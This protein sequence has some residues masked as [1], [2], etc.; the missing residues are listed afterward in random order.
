MLMVM[1]MLMATVTVTW[2]ELA[3]VE[4]RCQRWRGPM[5]MITHRMFSSLPDQKGPEPDWKDWSPISD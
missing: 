4:P 2:T 5:M 1:E 3:H